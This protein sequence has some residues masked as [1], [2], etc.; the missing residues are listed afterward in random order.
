MKA[1]AKAALGYARAVVA[2]KVPAGK[3]TRL[4]CERHLRDLEDG[5]D[6]GLVFDEVAAQH[7]VEFFR[8]LK[9][10]KGE[11]AGQVF[12]LGHAQRELVRLE[13]GWPR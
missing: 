4:A 8:F 6:R 9:H 2:G 1:A 7:A 10:S 3:W 5:A 13:D 11:W 12:E